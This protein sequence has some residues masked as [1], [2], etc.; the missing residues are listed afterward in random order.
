MIRR[1]CLM[2][3]C[4]F[5]LSLGI[6]SKGWPAEKIRFANAAKVNPLYSLPALAAADKGFWKGNGL[7]G[8]WFPFDA[9]VAMHQ[10]LA[11]G[12]VDLGMSGAAMTIQSIASGVPEVIILDM[13]TVEHFFFWV[14]RDSPIKEPKELKGIKIGTSRLGSLT[15]AF[16]RV[17]A[18]RLGLEREFKF[19]A[20]GATTSAM[21]A[22]K[23]GA[24][25]ASINSNLAMARLKF[26][27]EVRE[28]LAVRDYL[29]SPW[30]D[31]VVAARK[32]L[33]DKNPELVRRATRAILQ[34]NSF[35]TKNPE[36][37]VEKMKS[38]FN[39]PQE[40]ASSL[41]PFLKYSSEGKV[42][43]KALENVRN[44]LIEYGIVPE[45][46]VPKLEQLY[47]SQFTG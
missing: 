8:E 24:V 38:E 27:G 5:L 18:K 40:L 20:V 34:A 16:G 21:A 17:V 14:R 35:I 28:L 25:G 33:V 15:H 4:A 7:E 9:G 23:S 2:A 45:D 13:E 36:W 39:F 31:L 6:F 43:A 22:L 12:S 11:S 46:K 30:M 44:F 32:E 47:T 41:L 37:A 19:V 26:A 42:E 10:A 1:T 3:F 29:P